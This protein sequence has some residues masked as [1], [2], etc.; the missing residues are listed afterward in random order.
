MNFEII[1]D[2]LYV[3]R[4][5]TGENVQTFYALGRYISVTGSVL[6]VV[7]AYLHDYEDVGI[8][9]TG[10]TYSFP[11]SKRELRTRK[12]GERVISLPFVLSPIETIPSN[13]W[14]NDRDKLV[15]ETK[16]ADKARHEKIIAGKA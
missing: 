15:E 5:Y 6:Y 7:E 1:A 16:A 9:W 10:G 13:F 11:V 4:I 12:A 8:E 2:K 14:W 3:V